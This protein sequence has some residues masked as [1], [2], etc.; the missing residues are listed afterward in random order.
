MFSVS[1]LIFSATIVFL[2][3]FPLK[4]SKAKKK[5]KASEDFWARELEANTAR[6]VNPDTIDYIKIPLEALPFHDNPDKELREIQDSIKELAKERLLNLTGLSNTD[7]KL[8]YGVANFPMVSLCDQRFTQLAHV[9]FQWGSC[10]FERNEPENAQIVLEYAV[11]QKTDISGIYTLLAD[12]YLQ[13]SQPEKVEE[14]ISLAKE[15]PTLMKDSIVKRLQ[16]KL[17]GQA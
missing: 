12:I 9:L 5:S 3:V 11:S 8:A 13:Q 1:Y 6:R 7:I 15:L 17:L 16:E 4:L 14:L 10:L 2:V